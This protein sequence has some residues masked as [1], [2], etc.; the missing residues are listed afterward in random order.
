MSFA[1]DK[2]EVSSPTETVK[3]NYK[4][5]VFDDPPFVVI[6]DGKYS[7]ISID[8]WEMVAAS[9][10]IQYTYYPI[11]TKDPMVAL[12]ALIEK[13]YDVLL[14]SVT[15]TIHQYKKAKSLE[16]VSYSRAYFVDTI[17]A[18][19][20]KSLSHFIFITLKMLAASVGFWVLILSFLFVLYVMIWWKFERERIHDAPP[21]Q[22]P[23]TFLKGI[24][25]TIWLHLS[26]GH[27]GVP[28]TKWGKVSLIGWILGS[29]IS[30]LLV[31]SSFISFMTSNLQNYQARYLKIS[32]LE[33]IRLVAAKNRLSTIIAQSA[34]LSPRKMDTFEDAILELENNRADALIV[35][36]SHADYYLR[37]SGNQELFLAPVTIQYLLYSFAFPKE[38]SL[39][40]QVNEALVQF[41]IDG[42]S[43]GICKNYL[44][45]SVTGCL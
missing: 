27:G 21:T 35:T 11:P 28:E 16:G 38:G 9:L 14:G 31:S 24:H 45:K 4:V 6:Q 18:L 23:T 32:D 8:L 25:Y 15:P 26:R 44:S 1:E 41:H 19:E 2:K 17:G 7:G 42:S 43:Q 22:L 39:K 33:K 10:G 34:G 20:N 29:Y 30:M 3:Q 12:D 40:K 5:A 13:Q 36:S 37:E